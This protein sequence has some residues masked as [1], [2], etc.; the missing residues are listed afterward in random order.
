[1][2]IKLTPGQSVTVFSW[3]SPRILLRWQDVVDSE[4][5]TF[6][7]LSETCNLT[8]KQLHQLQPSLAEWALH[9]GVTLKTAVGMTQLWTFNAITDLQL[10]IGEIARPKFTAEALKRLGICYSQMKTLGLSPEIMPMFGLTLH[11]WITLGLERSDVEAMTQ[12]QSI[13]VFSITREGVLQA[14]PKI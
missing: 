4:K 10:D 1:M 12:E 14:M 9:G 6:D 7:F 3:Y 8:Y 5:L 2:Q 13:N 11:S